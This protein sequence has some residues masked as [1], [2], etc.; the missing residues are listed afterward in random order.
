M[1][2]Y[3]NLVLLNTFLRACILGAS[4]FYYKQ[5]TLFKT[6]ISFLMNISAT[7]IH[8]AVWVWI[9]LLIST[10][11]NIKSMICA[12][13]I[14]VRIREACPGQSTKVNWKYFYF[15]FVYSYYGTRVINE[16][17]PKSKVIPLYFDWGLLSRLAVDAI[18]VNTLQIEVF[19][20]ST[21]PKTPTLMFIQSLG[22]MAAIYSF[23]I[24]KSSFYMSRCI[25]FIIMF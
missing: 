13:P 20:E 17:K 24:S 1:T 16:E 14:I 19:P 2:S 25:R 7:I 11:K 4:C 23:Y 15:T 5:S 12:P 3:P 21:W 22:L 8:Y 18:C 10:T 9:P 6:T